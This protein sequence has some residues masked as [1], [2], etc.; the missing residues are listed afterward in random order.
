MLEIIEQWVRGIAEPPASRVIDLVD[1]AG[2]A[3][4]IARDAAGNALGGV[5]LPSLEVPLGSYLPNNTGAGFCFLIGSFLPF[6]GA[7]LASRYPDHEGYVQRVARA[8]ERAVAERFLLQAD[9]ERLRA[10]AA[11]SGIGK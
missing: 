8:A 6:D 1:G 10:E 5:R 9:A 3:R 7:Q 4:E 2:G 11:N